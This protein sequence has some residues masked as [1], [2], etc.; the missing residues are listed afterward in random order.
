M[1]EFLGYCA[2]LFGFVLVCAIFGLFAY[3]ILPYIIN[4]L[5]YIIYIQEAS[6]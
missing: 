2:G 3:Y 6:W 1:E 5:L 4:I